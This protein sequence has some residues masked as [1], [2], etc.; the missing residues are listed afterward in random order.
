MK[1]EDKTK[2]QLVNEVVELRERLATL[3]EIQHQW[4]KH[5]KVPQSERDR[6][7]KIMQNIGVGVAII[8]KDFR[9]VWANSV[10]K[11]WFGPG[12]EGK[13]CYVTYNN[14]DEICPGCGV[15][16]IFETAKDL[17]V[18]EQVGED[19]D[20]KQSVVGPSKQIEMTMKGPI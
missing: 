17:V 11:K 13:V 5:E 3:V 15:H 7:G 9:T 4:K 8:S 12:I 10:L 18:H 6:L 2:R 1:D 20:G 16:E 14:R 19:A